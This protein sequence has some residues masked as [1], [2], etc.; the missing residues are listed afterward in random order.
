MVLHLLA[1][2]KLKLL[3]A[4][5]PSYNP[6]FPLLAYPFVL[7][8]CIVFHG[9]QEDGL[10]THKFSIRFFLFRL[11]HVIF[12]GRQENGFGNA[13]RWRRALRLVCDL[14]DDIVNRAIPENADLPWSSSSTQTFGLITL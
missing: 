2:V 6:L 5:S 7:K 4:T 1:L 12:H 9:R 10:G 3:A 8:V 11:G 14:V 13:S